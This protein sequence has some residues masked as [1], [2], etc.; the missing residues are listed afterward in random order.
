MAAKLK[1]GMRVYVPWGLGE[2][3]EGTVVDVWGDPDSPSQI[4]VELTPLE[5][6]GE[7]VVLLLGPD[8]VTTAA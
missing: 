7:G 5:D 6:E 1:P 2:P 8:V 3:R 4:R